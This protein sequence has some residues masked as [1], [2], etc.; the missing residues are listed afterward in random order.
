MIKNATKELKS[1]PRNGSRKVANTFTV[2]DRNLE[3]L[4]KGAILKEMW[5]K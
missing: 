5:L 4:I 3:L 1:F 2:S